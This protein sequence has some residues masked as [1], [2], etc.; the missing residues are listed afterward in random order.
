MMNKPIKLK[1]RKDKREYALYKG[2]ELIMIGTVEE[3]A[4]HQGVK[5]STIHFYHSPTYKKRTKN[6]YVLKRIDDE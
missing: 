6:G 5:E 4:K 2:D 3:I 1:P